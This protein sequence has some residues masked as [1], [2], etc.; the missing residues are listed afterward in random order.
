MRAKKTVDEALERIFGAPMREL[1]PK[2]VIEPPAKAAFGDLSTNAAMLL[3]KREGRKPRELAEELCGR[4]AEECPDI[5]S[6]EAAGPGFCNLRFRPS[7]W[8]RAVGRIE[9]RGAAYGESGMGAGKKV[10]VEYVSA[11]PTGPLHVGHGRG[12]ALGDSLA[13]LLR[14]QG[15]DVNTEY[16]LNDAGRQMRTLGLSI[17]LRLLECSGRNTDYPEDCYQGAYIRDLARELLGARPELADLSEAEGLPVCQNFGMENILSGIR[18]DLGDFRCSHDRY[19]SEKSLVD[20]GK[21]DEAFRVLAE[22]GLTYEKDGALWF[23]SESLG[24]SKDR[25]LR[26]S[27]GSLTYFATDIAYHHDKFL[28][29]YGLLADLWGADHHGYIARLKGGVSAMGHDPD[30]FDILIIQLVNLLRGGQPVA[31]STRAGQFVTLREV[32]DEVGIDAA[33]FMFLSRKSDSPL[34]FD[35]ALARERSMDNPVY[36]VQYAHARICALLRRAG[37]R[38]LEL[39]PST[40]AAVL[41]RLDAPEELAMLRLLDGFEDTLASAARARAPHHVSSY[42]RELAS[43][44]HSYYGKYQILLPDDAELSLARLALLR[45]ARQVLRNGLQLLGVEAPEAM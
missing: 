19:F 2:L 5:A 18:K 38:G 20:A 37:E 43:M 35:L 30:D 11:N 14:S 36:Y 21:V 3:A 16:Y 7:F 26:K 32:M 25:V 39:A 33:R 41:S 9:E 15:Y 10:L 34:D 22:K 6:A 31:M 45:A 1:A 24:D 40:D 42:L 8:Q 13:R 44:V 28:R 23:R 4:L 12:A 29:G 17:W 27:D